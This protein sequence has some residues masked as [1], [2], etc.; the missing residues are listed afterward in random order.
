M[1]KTITLDNEELSV[2]MYALIVAKAN[3]DSEVQVKLDEI[4][5]K[6]DKTSFNKEE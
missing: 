4:I 6:M 1:N 3:L 2:I 5:Y